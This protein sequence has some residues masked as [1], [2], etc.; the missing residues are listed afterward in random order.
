MYFFVVFTFC[1]ISEIFSVYEYGDDVRKLCVDE[2]IILICNHQST[3]D[4]PILMTTL[5]SKGVA[6]RKVHLLLHD[7]IMLVV[8]R[9]IV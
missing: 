4:V 7:C 3:A 8:I 6:S 5:Q 9:S 2:R 1:S